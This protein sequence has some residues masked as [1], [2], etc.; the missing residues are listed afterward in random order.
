MIRRLAYLFSFYLFLSS[1][2]IGQTSVEI[3][4]AGSIERNPEISEANRLLGGVKLGFGDA[5]LFCDSAYR[6]DDGTFEVF[7]NVRVR[8]KKEGSTLNAEYAV[9][10]P[11]TETIT[12]SRGVNFTHDG[13]TLEC[14]EIF[15]N[16]ESKCVSYYQ[17]ATI[18]DGEKNMVSD[19]GAYYSE[20]DNLYAGGNVV[21]TQEA[22]TILS[23]SLSLNRKKNILRL[24][25]STTMKIDESIIVC[26]RGEYNSGK[27]RGWFAGDAS[28]DQT[29]GYLAGDSIYINQK[30]DIGRA[31]GNVMVK[32]SARTMTITGNYANKEDGV[33]TILGDSVKRVKAV[34]IEGGDTLTLYSNTLT[35][36]GELMYSTG[37]VEFEQGDF[38][39]VGDSLSWRDDVVWLLGDPIVHAKEND[40]EGDSVKM[41]VSDNKP[42]KM[43]LLTNA[44]VTSAVN[45]SLSNLLT[46]KTLDAFFTEGELSK[47]EIRGNGNVTYYSDEDSGEIVRNKAKCSNIL[48]KFKEGDIHTITLVTSPEGRIESLGKD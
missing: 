29:M 39:G 46:G 13:M 27:E 1:I 35:Q 42:Q 48:M 4:K 25:E 33:E 32:D 8:Q 15:Y 28:I 17:P 36:E 10:N 44:V 11:E 2:A 37:N 9:L 38:S 24:Y 20:S 34:N 7:S 45:D 30:K 40:L 18:F 21:I 47:V 43:S 5:V 16:I 12:V 14:P 6:F 31:W 41:I 19:N 3:L 22:D 23:D 26:T